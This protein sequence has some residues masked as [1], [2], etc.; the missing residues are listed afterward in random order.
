MTGSPDAES[1]PAGTRLGRSALRVLDLET[2]T[3]FYRDV[4]G[5]D[6]IGT[7]AGVATLGV[8]S[9]PLLVLEE[10]T[11]GSRSRNAAGLYHNAFRVPTR[12]A[13]GDAVKRLREDGSLEGASDHRVSEALYSTD[14]EGNGVEIYRDYPREDW[15]TTDDGRVQMTTDSLDLDAV[16]AA[17]TGERGLPSGSDIGH[18]HLEVTSLA[19]FQDC[20]ASALGFSMRA[21]VPGANFVAAGGYHHHVG[22]NTWHRRRDPAG[23]PGLAWF[24]IVVPDAD[25]LASARERLVAGG[26]SVTE[27]AAGFE[28]TD[29]DGFRVRLR[30]A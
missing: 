17:A 26:F 5:L 21:E 11:D 12:G 29:P 19:A 18:V 7:D 20:Y 3:A 13:L 9:T 8:S 28:F 14:P 15:P 25:V 22:A 24:E 30:A 23:G 10:T 1:L 27:I 2:V 6:V 16:A 4:V